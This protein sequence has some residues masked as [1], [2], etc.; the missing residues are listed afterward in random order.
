MTDTVKH[1]SP[2]EYSALVAL[3]D[4]RRI[5]VAQ[6]QTSPN[7]SLARKIERENTIKAISAEIDGLTANEGK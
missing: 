1:V 5:L 6:R 4:A 3:L 7:L 2:D